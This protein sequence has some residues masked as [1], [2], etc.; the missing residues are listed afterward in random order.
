MQIKLFLALIFTEYYDS[1]RKRRTILENKKQYSLCCL[2][3]EY[4]S[5]DDFSIER[6]YDEAYYY[7]KTIGL[8]SMFK[9]YPVHYNKLF[10]EYQNY[11]LVFKNKFANEKLPFTKKRIKEGTLNVEMAVIRNGR[12][13]IFQETKFRDSFIRLIE[14]YE[15]FSHYSEL[16]ESFKFN[17]EMNRFTLFIKSKDYADKSEKAMTRLLY[18]TNKLASKVFECLETCSSVE[19]TLHNWTTFLAQNCKIENYCIEYEISVCNIRKLP[20]L[21]RENVAFI[22]NC[23]KSMLA[24]LECEKVDVPNNELFL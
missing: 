17:K 3:D 16:V 2:S 22:N 15:I 9:K 4:N 21:T 13:K 5:S 10:E 11:L 7:F 18:E 24:F 12:Q 19:N 14:M 8:I 6:K 1:I 20:E 23:R